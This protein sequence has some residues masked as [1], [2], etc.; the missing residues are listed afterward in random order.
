MLLLDARSRSQE[1]CERINVA[2]A[3]GWHDFD[4]RQ[5]RLAYFS[6]VVS[7]EYQNVTTALVDGEQING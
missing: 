5:Q 3:E 4:L 2:M 1:V 6:A 7:H